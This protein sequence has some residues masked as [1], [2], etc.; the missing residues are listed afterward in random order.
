MF[1]FVS[2]SLLLHIVITVVVPLVLMFK[3]LLSLKF[4]EVTQYKNIAQISLCDRMKYFEDQSNLVIYVPSNAS[5]VMRLNGWS[6]GNFLSKIKNDLPYS[7]EFKRAMLKTTIDLQKKFNASTGYTYSDEINLIFPALSSD[8][9]GN[10]QQHIFNGNS[11]KLLSTIPSIASVLFDRHIK[12]ELSKSNIENPEFIP[13]FS[14]KLVV[15]P[16]GCNYELMNYIIWR[17]KGDCVKNFVSM[18]AKTYIGIKKIEYLSTNDRI[19]KL[20]T[21]GLDLSDKGNIDF[22]QKHGVFIKLGPDNNENFYVFKNLKYS[23]NMTIFLLNKNPQLD[24]NYEELLCDNNAILYTK[25]TKNTLFDLPCVSK[26]N[27]QENDTIQTTD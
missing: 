7:T 3:L 15:F 22:S 20:K 17:S 9:D 4:F 8:S 2:F 19:N 18:Y 6:F 27:N 13:S 11:K 12:D 21:F 23:K 25:Q 16:E 26:T 14:A 5:F 24:D 10:I 1:W